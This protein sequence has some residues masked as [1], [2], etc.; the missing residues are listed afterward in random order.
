M[1][2]HLA[3]RRT[4][5]GNTDLAN[6]LEH[7]TVHPSRRGRRTGLRSSR[8]LT[9]GRARI[10][11]VGVH[12]HG[13]LHHKHREPGGTAV[14]ARGRSVALGVLCLCS[15][16]A[17]VDLTITNVALPAIGKAFDAGTN[18]L[19][20]T[21]DAYNIVLAGM[22]VLGGAVA[23]RYGRRRVFLVSYALFALGSL[24]A[25]FSSSTGALIASRAVMGLGAAGAI[26]PALAI[27]ASMYLPEKRGSAIGAFVVFGATGLAVGPIAGGLL[28][29]HF[30]W[31]SV[32]LVNVPIVA[33]GVVVGARTIPESRAPVPAGRRPALDV[34]GAVLSVAGLGALLFGVIEGPGRGWAAPLVIAAM[35][36]GAITL[37][38]FVAWEL[39]TSAP[40]FDVRILR[41]PLVATGAITLLMAY[42][43]LSSFLFLNPQYLLDV[44]GESIVSVG[45]LFV[46]FAVVFGACSL[47]AQRILQWQGARTTITVGLI[48]SAVACAILAVAGRGPLWTMVAGSVVLGAGLSV[49]IAPPSTVVMNDLPTAKAGDGSSLNFV[50]RFGGGAIGVAVVGSIL[51][52]VYVRNLDAALPQLSP[53]QANQARGSLQGALEAAGTMASPADGSLASTARDAFDSGATVAYAAIAVLA[54]IAAAIAWFT[55]GRPSRPDDGS[56][57]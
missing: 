15:L 37:A 50:S 41:R 18:E 8:L 43:L 53:E 39:R 4:L 42:L 9:G 12:D 38:V 16:T 51:A 54:L 29:D 10:R 47:Q 45:L 14:S 21:I 49:L 2:R 17:G 31:G 28:L 7:E 48:V 40:L 44:R 22:L 33:V 32:F 57:A 52:S 11:L 26:A 6:L 19:Q 34:V 13:R 46:P 30:W 35:T 24:A 20:W 3:K 55:L 5:E 23:D 56:W 36:L 25:A 1:G 27:V